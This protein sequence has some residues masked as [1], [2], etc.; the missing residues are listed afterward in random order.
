MTNDPR[1]EGFFHLPFPTFI[2][3]GHFMPQMDI[4]ALHYLASQ[5]WFKRGRKLRAAEVGSFTGASAL[6]LA[7][8]CHRLYCCDT[9]AGGTDPE[10]PIN[11]I[12]QRASGPTEVLNAFMDNTQH[13]CEAI[14]PFRK[15]SP[16]VTAY[17]RHERFDLVFL[18][19]D[20]SYSGL[21]ADIEAW[22]PL[23]RPGGILC[24]HD[25][26]GQFPGVE[27]AVV[28][29]FPDHQGKAHVGQTWTWQFHVIG[30]VWWKEVT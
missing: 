3:F 16:A 22:L 29:A 24:G 9:W 6:A 13:V 18:D 20:H 12:Y 8:Y 30:N 27:R 11:A 23:V 14:F 7:G 1:P 28:E 10:D 4:N 26:G 15:V 5:Q 21:K 19:G 2:H 17:L 25:F